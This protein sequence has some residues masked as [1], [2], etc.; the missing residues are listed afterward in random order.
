MDNAKLKEEYPDSWEGGRLS[1]A[2]QIDIGFNPHKPGTNE[3]RA[4]REGWLGARNESLTPVEKEPNM[5][6]QITVGNGGSKNIT[7]KAADIQ[8]ELQQARQVAAFSVGYWFENESSNT[9]LLPVGCKFQVR[10]R[11]EV[12]AAGWR[13]PEYKH[14]QEM[15]ERYLTALCEQTHFYGTVT[16]EAM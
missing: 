4:W 15:A 2:L 10:F 1:W 3:Y 8:R 6:F 14:T 16:W 5:N 11:T 9:R 13:S 7:E 12:P